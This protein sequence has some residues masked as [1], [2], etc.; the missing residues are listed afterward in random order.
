MNKLSEVFVIEEKT[1]IEKVLE[2]ITT[3]TNN[4]EKLSQIISLIEFPITLV[5]ENYYVDKV[6]RD[7]YYNYFSGKHFKYDRNCKRLSLF[8]G[9]YTL[10]EL[11]E[12]YK[13]GYLQKKFVGT[14]V[15][16]PLQNGGIGRT[17]L[18]P[19]QLNLEKAYIRTTEFDVE[20]LGML[21]KVNAFPFS[22]Q[23]SETMTCA[24][25]TIWAILEYYGTRYPEY[26]VVLPNEII[27]AVDKISCQRVTPSMGL[28]YYTVSGVLKEFGF[29]PRVYAADSYSKKE[30]YKK[31]FHYYV[32]SGIP[33]GVGT[34]LP[35]MQS[36]HST[37]CIGHADSDRKITGAVCEKG[38]YFFDSCNFY[39][40]YVTID[41]NQIP[42]KVESFEDFTLYHPAEVD[43]FVVPLYKRIVLEADKA[44]T[45]LEFWLSAM[46]DVLKQILQQNNIINCNGN[47][48]I[49]RVFLTSSRKFKSFRVKNSESSEEMKIYGDVLYPKFLWVMEIATYDMYKDNKVCGEIVIDA[50]SAQSDWRDYLISLRVM[51]YMGYRKPDEGI[52]DLINR[53]E[54][55]N[56]NFVNEYNMYIN[57]LE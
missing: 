32:E 47:P 2:L 48:I 57:N 6:Y 55:S 33:I 53:F 45:C 4:V 3:N 30:V 38:L 13:I 36:G 51:N 39:D 1:E 14:I 44:A 54:Y 11:Y 24:E 42:Y 17:L 16:R 56:M 18:N 15:L 21:L 31:I 5:L 20:I 22:E 12:K 37:V 29:Q 43:V 27:R 52:Q 34:S 7:I 46:T 49:K 25:T 41:D 40:K 10:P 28:D 35:S 50:T 26:K 19:L 23:D 9:K 8:K